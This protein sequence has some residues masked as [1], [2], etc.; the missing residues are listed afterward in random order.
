MEILTDMRVA[1]SCDH[2]YAYAAST[3]LRMK[4]ASECEAD[5]IKFWNARSFTSIVLCYFMVQ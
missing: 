1:F 2:D 4:T 5:L 3:K